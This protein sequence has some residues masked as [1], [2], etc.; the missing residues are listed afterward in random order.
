MEID[1]APAEDEKSQQDAPSRSGS[2]VKAERAQLYKQLAPAYEVLFPLVIRNH[3]RS[4]IQS[5]D[6]PEG[7]KV[8]EVGIGTGV[9]MPVY[10]QHAKITGIDLSEPMLE[11]AQKRIQREGWDHFDLR[12][13]NAEQ[14]D[15]PDESFDFVTAFHVVTVVSKP[16]KMMAEITRVLKPGGRLLVINHFRSRRK[17]IANMVDRADSVTRHLGWRTNLECQ[18]I[19]ENLPLEVER[20]Y[21]SSPFSL[22]TIVKAKRC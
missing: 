8:L 2:K 11:V 14:L 10:P 16:Q 5:L 12:A 4:S 19:I 9:S 6:I 17:W 15:F 1:V 3:I 20:R 22:F 21:K 7:S 18:S 13:M